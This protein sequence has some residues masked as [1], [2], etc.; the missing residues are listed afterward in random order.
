M[1]NRIVVG[2]LTTLNTMMSPLGG[3]PEGAKA[4]TFKLEAPLEQRLACP[5]LNRNP[6]ILKVE[7]AP[8]SRLILKIT[9]H[10]CTDG[11]K[12]ELVSIGV[13]LPKA[14][15]ESQFI[16]DLPLNAPYVVSESAFGV[17]SKTGQSRLKLTKR[18]PIAGT[19]T[20]LIE[21][22]PVKADEEPQHEPMTLWLRKV[23]LEDGTPKTDLVW[24]RIEIHTLKK[25]V[26]ESFALVEMNTS[27]EQPTRK[28]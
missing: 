14:V 19:Y 13:S 25:R 11:K 20:L 6:L 5:N 17:A 1:L 22:I 24:E 26:G 10:I 8:E 18:E 21:W 2:T 16:E 27:S 9:G 4:L 7:P 12:T 15:F 28:N 3:Q 23:Y